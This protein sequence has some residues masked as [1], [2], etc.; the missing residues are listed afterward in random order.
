MRAISGLI[1]AIDYIELHSKGPTAER[2]HQNVERGSGNEGRVLNK[3]ICTIAQKAKALSS[4]CTTTAEKMISRP[5]LLVIL[6]LANMHAVLGGTHWAVFAQ[7]SIAPPTSLA[8]LSNTHTVHFARQAA[9]QAVLT[10]FCSRELGNCSRPSSARRRW[11][12]RLLTKGR[13]STYVEPAGA[14]LT[15]RSA[16]D[17]LTHPCLLR[18]QNAPIDRRP[19]L[20]ASTS[21][22]VC[23]LDLLPHSH[24][25]LFGASSRRTRAG[26]SARG[27]HH[28]PAS[29]TFPESGKNASCTARETRT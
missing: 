24:V 17:I 9:S 7:G 4:H 14:V 5:F 25:R 16:R 21:P 2:D 12:R 22:P 8:A 27:I 20:S 1:R 29:R 6:A 15:R 19:S 10:I 28:V 26:S 3:R 23:S 13:P 11:R 18:R